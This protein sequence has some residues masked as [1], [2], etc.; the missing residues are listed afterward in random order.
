MLQQILNRYEEKCPI[1]VYEKNN[2][3]ARWSVLL[4][5]SKESALLSGQSAGW[6]WLRLENILKHFPFRYSFKT[7]KHGEKYRN[8]T[9]F[10]K[11][12]ETTGMQA[13]T[14]GMKEEEIFG[15]QNEEVHG[16]YT[17]L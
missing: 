14:T 6:L 12:T 10:Q 2:I 8:Q 1:N 5:V 16:T 4:V 9:K 7:N 13:I 17:I 11:I 3:G 15:L